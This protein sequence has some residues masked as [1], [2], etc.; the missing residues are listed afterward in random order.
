MKILGKTGVK[1]KTKTIPI[2]TAE[3]G[4]ELELVL[5]APS[6][7]RVQELQEEIEEQEPVKPVP[8]AGEVMRDKRKRPLRD[9][10]GNVITQQNTADPEYQAA[11]K[12]Y[13]EERLKCNRGLTMAMLIE[14]LGDQVELDAKRDAFERSVDFYDKVWKEL[15][16]FGIGLQALGNLMDAALVVCG[17]SEDELAGARETLGAEGN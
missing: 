10:D 17:L 11:L 4:T 5:T 9:G 16:E 3:D 14:C 6:L 13:E 12:R 8:P 15:Q 1:P 2:G 7:T